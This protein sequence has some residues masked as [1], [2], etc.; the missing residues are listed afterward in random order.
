MKG[1]GKLVMLRQASG[2]DGR[3]E[4]REERVRGTGGFKENRCAKSGGQMR[5]K[6]TICAMKENRESREEGNEEKKRE[7]KVKVSRQVQRYA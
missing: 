2:R 3:K 6:V 7:W 4:Q 1:R 5:T